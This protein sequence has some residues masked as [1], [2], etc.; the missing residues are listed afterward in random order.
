MRPLMVLRLEERPTWPAL[1]ALARP[2]QGA[3]RGA[4]RGGLPAAG[5]GPGARPRRCGPG[6]RLRA[7]RGPAPGRA[8][9][10]APAGV[11]EAAL[12]DLRLVSELLRRDWHGEAR[13]RAQ[14]PLPPLRGSRAPTGTPGGPRWRRW[15]RRCAEQAEDVLA[16]LQDAPVV[17][18]SDR[19]HG[20]SRSAGRTARCEGSR[21]RT[22]S[23]TRAGGYRR[24]TAPADRT[25]RRCWRGPG[26][27]HAAVR[28]AGSGKSTAVRG[29]LTRFAGRGLRLLEVPAERLEDLPAVIEAVR[30]QPQR[31]VLYVDDLS[32]EGGDRRYHPLKTVLEGSLS[33]RPENVVLYATS[34]RRHLLGE[35]HGDRPE[36]GDEDVHAWDTHNERLALAD[37]FGLTLTFPSASQRR[38]LEIVRRWPGPRASR[39]TWTRAR[40]DS[41]TG[42]TATRGA[43]RASSSMPCCRNG[44]RDGPEH[45]G[46]GCC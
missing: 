16:W 36:L 7:A 41:P 37:R 3:R 15:R 14:A 45:R 17:P 13:P 26:P 10:R 43:R 21:T 39:R 6:A 8:R 46:P 22:W 40:C 23:T 28:A 12:S 35:H 33:L 1:R 18:A 42:A 11:G 24:S 38:Y 44:P 32:F 25:P 2:R 30:G 5:A 31:F 27:Q 34:N 9:R 4:G 19:P 29:L 20:S